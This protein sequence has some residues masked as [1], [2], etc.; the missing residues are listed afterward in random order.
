MKNTVLT[1]RTHNFKNLLTKLFKN[2]SISFIF[3]WIFFNLAIFLFLLAW[4]RFVTKSFAMSVVITV[5]ILAIINVLKYFF[6]SKKRPSISQKK[7]LDDTK[8]FFINYMSLTAKERTSLLGEAFGKRV[9]SNLYKDENALTLIA[10]EQKPLDMSLAL[11][12]TKF[13]IKRE[14]NSLIILCQSCQKEDSFLLQSIKN[15]KIKIYV[16]EKA[17]EYFCKY[18]AP[19][20]IELE[21]SLQRKIKFKEL[22]SEATA[23]SKAKKYFFSGLLIF[24]C[25]LVVKYNIY[26]VLMSSMLFFLSILCM[27]KKRALQKLS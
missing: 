19:P 11:S 18:S 15:I 8:I 22:A 13:A 16:F 23:P 3:D 5:V 2:F 10:L 17:Y 20:K 14:V 26:Y 6:H 27:S 7:L 9:K 21:C 4:I 1:K 24:F 12:C 25:S